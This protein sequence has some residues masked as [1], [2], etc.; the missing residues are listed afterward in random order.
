MTYAPPLQLSQSFLAVMFS[1]IVF[2][3]SAYK[4]PNAKVLCLLI[5]L[6]KESAGVVGPPGAGGAGVL[7]YS[8]AGGAGCLIPL[9]LEVLKCLVPI[10]LE[11]MKCLVP[12][13]LE[14]LGCLTTL[15]HGG[16]EVLDPHGSLRILHIFPARFSPSSDTSII[17][18][19]GSLVAHSRTRCWRNELGVLQPAHRAAGSELLY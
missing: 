5:P 11:V 7:D 16:A 1:P 13:G 17:I 10:G 8:G 6:S 12:L 14:V 9:E 2:L 18:M 4:V 3:S 19:A 15:G